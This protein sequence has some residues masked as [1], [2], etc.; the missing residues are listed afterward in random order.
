LLSCWLPEHPT[1]GLNRHGAHGGSDMQVDIRGD[2]D[3]A[4]AAVQQGNH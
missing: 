3:L 2:A 1:H 4:V